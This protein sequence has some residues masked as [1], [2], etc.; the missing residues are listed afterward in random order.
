MM[1]D[2]NIKTGMGV[3]V[4]VQQNNTAS[5]SSRGRSFEALLRKAR[6]KSGLTNSDN[7]VE[8]EFVDLDESAEQ[9]SD[10]EH[11]GNE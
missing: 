1:A 8:G 6:E 9:F 5:E 11:D 3:Q 2:R 10:E 7:V 4:N